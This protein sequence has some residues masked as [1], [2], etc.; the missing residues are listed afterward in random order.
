MESQVP[1]FEDQ[2]ISS[3]IRIIR[4]EN[5]AIRHRSKEEQDTIDKRLSELKGLYIRKQ[6]LDALPNEEKRIMK[7]LLYIQMLIKNSEKDGT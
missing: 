3:C 2:F 5:A 4:D 6:T 1:F 7:C